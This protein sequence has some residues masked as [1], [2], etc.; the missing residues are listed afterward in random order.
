MLSVILEMAVIDKATYVSFTGS[1]GVSSVLGASAVS[2]AGSLGASSAAG[3]AAVYEHMSVSSHVHVMTINRT[4]SFFSVFLEAFSLG[5]F[6]AFSFFSPLKGARSLARR[7]GLLGRS[8]FLASAAGSAC[9]HPF[10]SIKYVDAIAKTYRLSLLGG[11]RGLLGLGSL[12]SLSGGGSLI[13][14]Q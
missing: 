2:A 14:N 10:R 8:S 11:G 1:A 7:E 4:S 9:S 12:S 6:S 3:A 13:R 5:F